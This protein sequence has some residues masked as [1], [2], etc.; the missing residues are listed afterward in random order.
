GNV[1][2]VE[3]AAPSARG[4]SGILP[5]TEVLRHT[6]DHFA[7]I[8]EAL[9]PNIFRANG[10]DRRWRGATTDAGAG[11]DN[12]LQHSRLALLVGFLARCGSGF[13]LTVR[14]IR[15]GLLDHYGAVAGHLVGKPTAGEQMPQRCI[16]RVVP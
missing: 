5:A 1:L 8:G 4:H 6:A 13:R 16:E 11:H 12:G 15:R 10:D 7:E 3:T 2:I 14:R 9:L